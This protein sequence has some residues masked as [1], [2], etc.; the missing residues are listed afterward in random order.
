ME[1]VEVEAMEGEVIMEKAVEEVKE[2]M[3]GE[4]GPELAEIRNKATVE[5][6]PPE[7]ILMMNK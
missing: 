4:E 7:E 3:V 6:E 2:E 1:E 5:V